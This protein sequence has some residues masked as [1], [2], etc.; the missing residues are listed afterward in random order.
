MS[1]TMLVLK[2][3]FH[4]ENDSSFTLQRRTLRDFWFVKLGVIHQTLMFY[5]QIFDRLKAFPIVV[6]RRTA[7]LCSMQYPFFPI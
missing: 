5:K 6:N 7:M 3:V 2:E 1:L 4:E